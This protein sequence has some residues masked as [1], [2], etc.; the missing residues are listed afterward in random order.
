MVYTEAAYKAIAAKLN[1]E[2]RY[3]KYRMWH[4]IP[5]IGDTALVVDVIVQRGGYKLL[6]P[7]A[8]DNRLGEQYISEAVASNAHSL[9]EYDLRNEQR[10]FA[11]WK[12]RLGVYP[13]GYFTRR[14]GEDLTQT[15][16]DRVSEC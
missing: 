3:D 7:Q 11:T 1:R 12:S 16:L 14:V 2:F 6:P 4:H 13:P 15:D 5:H 9:G 8:F 10:R